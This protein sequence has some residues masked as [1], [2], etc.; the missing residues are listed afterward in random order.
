MSAILDRF[1]LE[2]APGPLVELDPAL[3][4]ARVSFGTLLDALAG[5]RDEQL[6]YAWTWR[7][8]QAYIRYGFYRVLEILEG[9]TAAARLAL[10][11]QPS[12][13]AREAVGAAAAARWQLHGILATLN[14]SDL[15]ADPGGGEWTIRRTMQHIVNSQ[16]GYAWGSAYWLSVRDEPRS[17][18]P[19][20]RSGRC[21]SGLP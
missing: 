18:R 17:T 15:D 13:E 1:I 16:R 14:D 21:L 12:S 3:V 2:K 4:R 19:A 20:T 6:I 8:N 7:D 5:I 9:A 10:A 11:S